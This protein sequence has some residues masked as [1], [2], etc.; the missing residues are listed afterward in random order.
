LFKINTVFK[1]NTAELPQTFLKNITTPVVYKNTIP[2]INPTCDVSKLS[3][4]ISE[5]KNER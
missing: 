4:Y 5:I 3:E 1:L 2:T